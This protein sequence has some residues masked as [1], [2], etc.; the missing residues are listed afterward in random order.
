MVISIAIPN[1][2]LKTNTVDGFKGIC[3]QP[4]NPAV[5]NKGMTFGMRE[6]SNIRADLNK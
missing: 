6:I 1:A 2:T 4:I 3:N 5:I